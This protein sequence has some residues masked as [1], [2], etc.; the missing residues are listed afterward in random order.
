MKYV[1]PVLL[2]FP[3]FST[4]QITWSD[5]IVVNSDKTFGFSRPKVVIN[6]NGQPVV[7]WG[8]ANNKGVYVSHLKNGTFEEPQLV[9]PNDVN[10]FAQDWA[11]PGI[12]G[13]GNTIFIVFKSQP[14]KEGF[15]YVAKSIDGGKTFGDT[16]R[17]SDHNWS[18]FPNVTVDEK[19]NPIVIFMEF[20]ED[21]LEPGYVVYY[22]T[23]GG[24]TF[25]EGAEATE[26]A[27]GEACDCCPAF[28]MVDAGETFVLYRN[29]DDDLRDIWASV[30]NDNGASFRENLDIDQN[31]WSIPVCPSS[32]PWAIPQKDSIVA[33]WMSDK[34]NYPSVFVGAVERNNLDLGFQSR[35]DLKTTGISQNFPK[36]AGNG[37]VMGMVWQES[38]KGKRQAKF[39]YSTSGASGLIS[40]ETFY[41]NQESS[42][43]VQNPFIAYNNGIFHM[44][45]ENNT[46][47]NVM[48]RTANT[49]NVGLS[50]KHINQHL[51]VQ[52]Q[53]GALLKIEAP[54]QYENGMVSI[55]DISGRHVVSNRQLN[56]SG[57]VKL[58]NRQS[59]VLVVE[60]R[61]GGLPPLQGKI[62]M[63]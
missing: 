55:I 51:K 23:D 20:E 35:V 17:V 19:G 43:N 16:V 30:S 21:W 45:W 59:G 14:E 2:L 60:V 49:G 61:S 24:K 42:T 9:T 58:P 22:S 48:Y 56:Q 47:G 54:S 10:A 15:V 46:N 27:P 3:F 37:Q 50:K 32:G 1:L 12:A 62:I 18:R 29:N 28:V 38:G 53:E 4:A 63:R 40:G 13:Y 39:T 5:P 26:T 33:V 34:D 31:N 57:I 7:M 44:V 25:V 41:I 6:A 8:K 11:G 36:I 52:Q